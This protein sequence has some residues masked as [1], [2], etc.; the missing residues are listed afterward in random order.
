MG[1]EK[2]YVAKRSVRSRLIRLLKSAVDPRA[3]AHMLKIINYYNYTHVA[4]LRQALVGDGLRISPTASISNGKNLVIG[5]RAKIGAHCSLW[6]GNGDAKI[7]LGDDVIIGPSVMIITSNYRFNDGSP[8]FDQAM[9]ERDITI[10]NDVWLGYGVVVLAGTTIG[11]GAI[12]GAN[13]VVRKDVAP[14]AILGV[15]EAQVIGERETQT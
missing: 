8:V 14:N 10:G 11:D 5:A 2:F 3:Y 15:A 12:I 6:A 4:E 9:N 7:T 1:D 13:V